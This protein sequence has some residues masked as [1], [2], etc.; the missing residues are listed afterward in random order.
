MRTADGTSTV[1]SGGEVLVSILLFGSI[2]VLLGALWLWALVREL[3]HGPEP[4][5]VAPAPPTVSGSDTPGGRG[6]AVVVHPRAVVSGP[7]G[8]A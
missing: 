5:P 1:V 4:A 6:P 2:Y 3:R 7:G 8:G